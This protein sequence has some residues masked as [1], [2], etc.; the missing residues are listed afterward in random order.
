M[1][2]QATHNAHAGTDAVV[3]ALYDAYNAH[4]TAAVAALYAPGGRH[5]E[6]AS[7]NERAGG[8]AI[9]KG[10]AT[11][12]KAFPDARWYELKRV[13]NAERAA[14]TYILTGTLSAP[15]GPFEPAGQRLE[16][17]G[18]HVIDV[19]PEGIELSED[20]WD[21]ATFGRQ[22]KPAGGVPSDAAAA[23]R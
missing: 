23:P 21:S 11:M 16:L 5:V 14:V 4:D 12:L 17:R 15:F 8:S 6:T 9:A 7:G 18:V 2:A 19:G 3:S 1:D 13:C 20:Y 22:M 10:L